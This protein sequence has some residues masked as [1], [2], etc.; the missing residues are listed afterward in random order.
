MEE[1][2]TMTYPAISNVQRYPSV[3]GNWTVMFNTTGKANLTIT[4]VNGTT[5]TSPL[6]SL[7][8]IT[9]IIFCI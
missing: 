2:L 1:E 8:V 9:D 5:W 7:V 3:G 6:V 4:A